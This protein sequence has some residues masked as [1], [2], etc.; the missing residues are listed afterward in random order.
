MAKRAK[1]YFLQSRGWQW[2]A[3][4]CGA[5]GFFMASGDREMSLGQCLA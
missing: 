4:R 3:A 2:I 1:K 5:E